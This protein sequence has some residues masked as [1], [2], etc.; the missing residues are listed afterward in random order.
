MPDRTPP[1]PDPLTLALARID[2]ADRLSRGRLLP[3]PPDPLA[4]ALRA[5]ALGVADCAASLRRIAA[6]QEADRQD[7]QARQAAR[8]PVS[9]QM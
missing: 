2:D 4:D 7:R 8:R 6:T 9:R 3:D 5:L 1:G